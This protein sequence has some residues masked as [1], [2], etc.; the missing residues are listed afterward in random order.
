MRDAFSLDPTITHLN[1]GSFGTVPRIVQERQST[2]RGRAE[3]NPMRF[4]RVESPGLKAA[5][6]ETAAKFLGV[7]ADEVALVRNVTQAAATVLSALAW[8]GRLG[9]GDVVLVN[10]QGY[11]SV[12]RTVDLWCARTCASY[13]VVPLPAS[14]T[15]ADVVTGYVAAL[16]AV[17]ARGGVPRLVVVDQISSPTGAVL[18]VAAV[19]Q[20]AHERG[21]LVL[22][23]GAHVPGHVEVSPAGTGADFWTGTWHKWGFAPR[24]TSALWVAEAERD[25]L[26]P[27]TTSWNHGQ[28]FPLPFD[29]HGTDDYSAWFALEAAV[30]FWREA[31]GFGLAERAR[32]LLEVGAGLIAAAAGTAADVVADPSPCMRLVPLPRGVADTEASA[33]RLY[34]ALS[35]R[36]IEAQVLA[37][38]GR[39]WIRL[40]GA[41]YNEPADYERLAAELPHVLGAV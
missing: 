6:R 14:A 33:D 36:R 24:G 19:A 37:Y 28:D 18:P 39:G 38:D 35:A 23:D 31:G 21:A 30:D 7:G 15:P 5:A 16:D 22:V 12:R 29:T 3:A 25:G 8:Q 11:E 9:A 10:Q 26:D 13:D 34:E 20:A 41:A 17:R 1:H 2:I 4:F 40:S 32:G 27:L